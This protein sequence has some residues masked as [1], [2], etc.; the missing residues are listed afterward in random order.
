M[1]ASYCRGFQSAWFIWALTHGWA[2]AGLRQQS[3][4]H[5]NSFTPPPSFCFPSVFPRICDPTRCHVW[6]SGEA[7]FFLW[8]WS[9]GMGQK[10][11]SDGVWGMD[12][13]P[14]VMVSLASQLRGHPR[15]VGTCPV[16]LGLADQSHLLAQRRRV[17]ACW[18]PNCATWW[19]ESFSS[20]AS[21][22]LPCS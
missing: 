16:T 20:M 8:C 1:W 15:T 6:L 18:I 21:L 7:G 11:W 10:L 19:T 12:S 2:S 14:L 13:A 22:S 5:W 17:L 4:V 3:C 9:K